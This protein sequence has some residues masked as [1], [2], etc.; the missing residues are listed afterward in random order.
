MNAVKISSTSRLAVRAAA[1]LCVLLPAAAYAASKPGQATYD[2]PQRAVDALVTA[3]KSGDSKQIVDVLGRDGREVASSGDPVADAAGR[4]LFLSAYD[5][6]HEL[7]QADNRATLVIGKQEF[8]F[9]IP[10]VST[11]E[12][13][14][15]DTQTGAEEILDR[16][17]GENEIAAIGVLKSYV[18]AQREY[19]ERDRDGKGVQYARRI[20]SSDGKSDGLYWPTASGEAESPFGPLIAYAR[21]EGYAAQAGRPTPY[22]GYLYRVLT[23]QGKDAKGGARNYIVN[24]R[25]IGGFALVASPAEYGNSGVMTFIVNQDGTIFQKNLGEAGARI[26]AK[27][28]EFNPGA[29]WTQVTAP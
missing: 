12:G 4:E 28:T 25:M 10:I 13:W 5:E 23:A 2:T 24:G 22:H 29:G 3:A 7:T 8:P 14:R 15:F 19:A 26:A 20:L 17:I 21:G 1:A 9:P 27:M 18:D 6:A 11:K 16:R